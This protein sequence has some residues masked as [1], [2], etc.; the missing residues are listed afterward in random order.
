LNTTIFALFLAVLS[1]CPRRPLDFGPRGEIRDPLELLSLTQ[2]A[3]EQ[4]VGVHGDGKARV[5]A[6][7]GKGSVGL[8]LSANRPDLVHL[9]SLDF[10][11]KP[12][13]MLVAAQGEFGL[14]QV[15]ENRYYR[16]PATAA[17]ISR[18]LPVALPPE[19][20]VAV[21]LGQAP[22]IPD[23][24]PELSVDSGE[25]A[26]KVKL[27]RDAVTQTLWIHPLHYRVIKSE[28]RGMDA[29]DLKFEDFETVGAVTFPRKVTLKAEAA[30][31]EVELRY[32]DATVN[33]PPDLTL[34]ELTPPENVPVVEVDALGRI[35][36]PQVR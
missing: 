9:E 25:R 19:E 2:A 27:Q 22:R 3:E 12:Q 30:S 31:T 23:D 10:F 28:L 36:E 5:E 26:Y 20:L 15:E 11:G 29:Y 16:G 4:V 14:Y 17:N 18:F 24:T 21:M 1:G 32:T 34:F 6:P 7:Q 8:F 13:A 33:A 35:S